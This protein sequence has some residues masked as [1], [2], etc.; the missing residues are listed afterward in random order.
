MIEARDN[1]VLSFGI[2]TNPTRLPR[3]GPIGNLLFSQ[4]FVIQ[5]QLVLV[6]I[7]FVGRLNLINATTSSLTIQSYFGPLRLPATL[8]FDPIEP[9]WFLV[10][11]LLMV[12]LPQPL[13][14]LTS[15]L[16]MI[17]LLRPFPT[18]DLIP[19]PLSLLWVSKQD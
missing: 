17:T 19:L 7:F 6:Y 14:P 4:S 1:L 8:S 16:A 11:I 15:S 9:S 3:S 13:S 2:H 18:I 5:G 10:R 12:L